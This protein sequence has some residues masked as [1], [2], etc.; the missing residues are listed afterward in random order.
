MSGEV[1]AQATGKFLPC[2]WWV[3]WISRDGEGWEPPMEVRC[4]ACGKIQQFAEESFGS[5]ASLTIKCAACGEA[6]RVVSP[7]TLSLRVDTTRRKTTP[8]SEEL[9]F[10][11]RPLRL[12]EDQT[13]SLRVQEGDERGTVYPLVK[14]RTLIGRAKA[15]IQVEDRMVSRLHCAVE[16][17]DDGVVLRDLNST[18]G[19][20]VNNEPIVTSMLVNGSTFR[21]GKHVFQL[22]IRPKEA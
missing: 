7:K 4:H 8:V 19:T 21:I 20:L 16:V 13:L 22:E 10:E 18:N 11:G 1:L 14:P 6:I 15:D 2:S 9:S 5:K 12:P 3:T 17:G